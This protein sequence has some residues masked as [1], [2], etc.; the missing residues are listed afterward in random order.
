MGE[1]AGGAVVMECGG[2]RA[3]IVRC[4]CGHMGKAHWAVGG[5]A[6]KPECRQS[7]DLMEAPDRSATMRSGRAA[8]AHGC[9]GGR[10]TSG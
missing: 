9:R 7:A 3:L 8:A 4:V 6:C 10:L 1:G 5:G 2:A